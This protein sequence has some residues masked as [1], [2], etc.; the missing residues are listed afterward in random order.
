MGS[1]KVNA[2]K[3]TER[4]VIV[5]RTLNGQWYSYCPETY[6][7]SPLFLEKKSLYKFLVLKNYTVEKIVEEKHD[8]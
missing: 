2:M 5:Y 1:G 8:V 6:A 7:Y 4:K 3:M